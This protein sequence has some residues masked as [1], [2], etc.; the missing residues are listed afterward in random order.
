MN[1]NLKLWTPDY[2]RAEN[3]RISHPETAVIFR[4]PNSIWLNGNTTV[5]AVYSQVVRVLRR[6]A[7]YVPTFVLYAIPGRDIGQHSAGGLS[8]P[9]YIA[10]CKA[11]SSAIGN[12]VAIVIIEPDAITHTAHLNP[13]QTARRLLLLNEV[14]QIF[15]ANSKACV[16]L[17]AGHPGWYRPADIKPLLKKAGIKDLA[18]FSV[19]V[20]NYRTTDECIV[21][22]NELSLLFNGKKRY[23]IDTSRNGKGPYMDEWCNPPGRAIGP[24]P[25]TATGNHLCDAFLWV[26]VPGESDGK[27]NGGPRA[28]KFWPEQ[29]TELVNNSVTVIS[30]CS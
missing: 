23:V 13:S 17:D 4:Y 7:G 29:A 19:N 27:C 3:Y 8:T 30:G 12:N 21:W 24:T 1:R 18:G 11:I 25:T 10:Y 2:N 5:K 9:E 15:A 22:G 20:S 28:G 6:A 16:Y 26:K 14:S